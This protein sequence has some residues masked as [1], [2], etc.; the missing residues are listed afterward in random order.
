MSHK[1]HKRDVSSICLMRFS[2]FIYLSLFEVKRGYFLFIYKDISV[3]CVNLVS[4]DAVQFIIGL[5]HRPIFIRKSSYSGWPL[6]IMGVAVLCTLFY[7]W[8]LAGH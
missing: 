7:S 3:F 1:E 2:I 5:N 6:R 8:F 4:S